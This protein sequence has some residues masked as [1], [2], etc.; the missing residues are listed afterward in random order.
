MT[1]KVQKLEAEKAPINEILPYI[2]GEESHKMLVNG[3][4]TKGYISCGQGIGQAKTIMPMKELF[5]RMAEEVAF[6]SKR[7]SAMIQ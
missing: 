7:L 6:V 3:D 2:L 4:M 1:D 5:Q